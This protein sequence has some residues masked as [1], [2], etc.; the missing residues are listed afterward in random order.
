M[1]LATRFPRNADKAPLTPHGFKNACKASDRGWPLVG[2]PTGE[3]TS[4]DVL[5]IDVERNAWFNDVPLPATRHQW[6]RSGGLHLFFRHSPGL[7]CSSGRVTAGVDV[8]AD[9]GYVIDWHR[10]GLPVGGRI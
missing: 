8:R 3:R 10:E 5:D 9:G 4:L 7:R 1:N 2:I 6:T